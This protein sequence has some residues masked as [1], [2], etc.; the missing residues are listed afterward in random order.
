MSQYEYYDNDM[1][2]RCQDLYNNHI[3]ER[4]TSSPKLKTET[5]LVSSADLFT[6][7]VCRYDESREEQR[8]HHLPVGR[9]IP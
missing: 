2:H 7:Q 9:I 1:I 3:T 4:I 5:A 8:E 6:I